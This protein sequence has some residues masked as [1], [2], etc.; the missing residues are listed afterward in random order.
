[1]RVNIYEKSINN[2]L[3]KQLTYLHFLEIFHDRLGITY[4][5][6]EKKNNTVRIDET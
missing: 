5:Y 4:C 3:A 2:K 6:G 1:M